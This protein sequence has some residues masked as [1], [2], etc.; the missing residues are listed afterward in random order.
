MKT[1]R[2]IHRAIA[3]P[4]A[5]L[6]IAAAG[7]S[8]KD[9]PTA[10]QTGGGGVPPDG[11]GAQT[12]SITVTASPSQLGLPPAGSGGEVPTSTITIQV[13]NASTGAPPA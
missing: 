3:L 4:V 2:R 11:A 13:R 12:W 1:T 5:L 6:A 9:S 8:G 7:C 10:P